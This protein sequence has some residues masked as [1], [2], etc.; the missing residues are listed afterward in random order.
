[1]SDLVQADLQHVSLHH[2]LLQLLDGF[3]WEV[4]DHPGVGEVG[5]LPGTSLR[6]AVA[7]L[8]LRLPALLLPVDAEFLQ[9][10]AELWPGQDGAG[11][12]LPGHGSLSETLQ[13]LALGQPHRQLL[14]RHQEAEDRLQPRPP[15]PQAGRAEKLDVSQ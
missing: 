11:P 7:G 2:D 10:G 14:E 9:G 6:L 8:L 4:D 15:A 13:G 3:G 1:M 5:F 12:V